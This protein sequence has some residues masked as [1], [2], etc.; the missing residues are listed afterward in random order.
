[1]GEIGGGKKGGLVYDIIYWIAYGVGDWE[2]FLCVG[3]CHSVS[4]GII[5]T[6]GRP[7]LGCVIV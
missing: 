4:S 6:M 2:K 7:L 1:M 5:F 3:E